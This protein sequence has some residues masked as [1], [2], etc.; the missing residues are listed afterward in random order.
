M[1]RRDKIREMSAH[2]GERDKVE[3]KPLAGCSVTIT[4][5]APGRASLLAS[6]RNEHGGSSPFHCFGVREC[7]FIG[8]HPQGPFLSLDQDGGVD[9]MPWPCSAWRS[10]GFG[11][12]HLGWE[13]VVSGHELRRRRVYR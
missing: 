5:Q 6:R 11:V 13:A 10:V 9:A 12:A 2:Y 1:E 4:P 8:D 7:L 3:K